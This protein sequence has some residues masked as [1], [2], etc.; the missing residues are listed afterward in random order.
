MFRDPDIGGVLV[1]QQAS[2]RYSCPSTRF[3][4]SRQTGRRMAASCLSAISNFHMRPD[5]G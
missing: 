2:I 5:M 3:R 1:E 4:L